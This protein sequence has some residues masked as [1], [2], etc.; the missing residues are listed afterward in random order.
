MCLTKR[1]GVLTRAWWSS[2]FSRAFVCFYTLFANALFCHFIPAL[3]VLLLSFQLSAF[4][5]NVYWLVCVCFVCC[6]FS[7]VA[8][9]T[10][11]F[12]CFSVFSRSPPRLPPGIFN[13][14][15]TKWSVAFVCFNFL[16]YI[17]LI[18]RTTRK[19]TSVTH[20]VQ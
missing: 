6:H 14:Y 18:T 20:N 4:F 3:Y 15:S 1:L 5:L 19:T 2:V 16:C 11:R 13:P 10:R 9:I 8:K 7:S 17:Q 12:L